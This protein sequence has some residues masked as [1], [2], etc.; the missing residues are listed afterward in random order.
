MN[1]EFCDP[2]A[3]SKGQSLINSHQLKEGIAVLLEARDAYSAND[4]SKGGKNCSSVINSAIKKLQEDPYLSL[5][6]SLNC[7]SADIKKSYRK[8]A[9]KYHPDKNK[10]TTLL[11]TAIQDAYD[12]LSDDDKRKAYD[13]RRRR[14]EASMEKL[15]KQRPAASKQ[16]PGP[17]QQVR[18][19][20]GAQN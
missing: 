13:I 15:R 4:G 6:L 16:Q 18:R 1:F 9:L 3:F 8:L 19:G 14:Q 2:V 17:S 7:S 11:F 12:T 20:P 10:C 5:G